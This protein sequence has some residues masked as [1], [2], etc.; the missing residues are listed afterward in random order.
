MAGLITGA[1]LQAGD[2][3]RVTAQLVNPVTEAQVWA[4]SYERPLRDVLS[5]ENEIV[6]AITREVKLRLTPDEKARLSTARP[7]NPESYEAYLKG[8]DQLYKKTPEGFEKGMAILQQAAYLDPTDPL[9]YAGLALAYPI[10][11]HGPGVTGFVPPN[12]GFPRAR[13]AALKALELDDRLGPGPSRSRGH[14]DVPRLGLGRRRAG[15]QARAGAEP[16][17]RRGSR[18]LRLVPRPV[19]AERRG[20]GRSEE[21]RSSWIP[22]RPSTPRGSAGCTWVSDSSTRPSHG[23]ARR[24]SS[25]RTSWTDSWSS[26]APT[27]GRRCPTRPS[28]PEER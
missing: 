26:R 11:Y 28:I 5:L 14:Q 21:R 25:T 6:T 12:E 15:V 19:R 16:E 3:V 20:G 10:M 2:R 27:T 4:R 8:M 17:P 22:S 23:P 13:A 1:V 18:A 7:V 24:S 9:P